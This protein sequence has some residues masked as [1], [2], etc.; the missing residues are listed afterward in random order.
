MRKAVKL[1][2]LG[3]LFPKLQRGIGDGIARR[4]LKDPVLE[5]AAQLWIQLD[6]IDHVAPHPGG[7]DQ[8]VNEDHRDAIGIVRLQHIQPRLALGGAVH[9][10]STHDPGHGFVDMRV[11]G[12]RR[13]KIRG[14]RSDR[15]GHTGFGLHTRVVERKR[16][17]VS[18]KIESGR[19]RGGDADKRRERLQ[20]RLLPDA[21][22]RTSDAF[23][24]IAALDGHDRHLGRGHKRREEIRP[25]D[26]T[27]AS[28]LKTKPIG[29][30]AG[31]ER[32]GMIPQSTAF[33]ASQ[34]HG[35]FGAGRVVGFN[36]GS[37]VRPGTG[38]GRGLC[39]RLKVKRGALFRWR[40]LFSGRA[41]VPGGRI[42]GR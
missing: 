26:A 37:G 34:K 27:F 40:G 16:G 38:V 35:Q 1:L 25:P 17:V 3:Q 13:G 23:L 20:R 28:G 36:R 15:P 30:G 12:E 39:R 31:L 33:G 14:Q 6:L 24:H 32:E 21:H 42:A 5:T 18:A 4:I 2:C 7:G 10:Q 29:A 9:A 19:D 22:E 41:Q 11:V 8:P